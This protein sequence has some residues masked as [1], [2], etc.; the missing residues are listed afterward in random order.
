MERESTVN[1]L[2]F[3]KEDIKHL[4]IKWTDS[5]KYH[6]VLID[7]FSLNYSKKRVSETTQHYFNGT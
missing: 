6:R 3:K 7:M 2:Q 1:S 5:R 4:K